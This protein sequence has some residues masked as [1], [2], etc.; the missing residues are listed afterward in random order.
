MTIIA[1]SRLHELSMP[2]LINADPSPAPLTLVDTEVSKYDVESPQDKGERGLAKLYAQVLKQLPESDEKPELLTVQDIPPTSSFGQLRTLLHKI[3]DS[4]QMKSWAAEK[5][6]NLSARNVIDISGTLYVPGSFG[7]GT[8]DLRDFPGWPL[9]KDVATALAGSG[10]SVRFDTATTARVSDIAQFYRHSLPFDPS[11]SPSEQDASITDYIAGWERKGTLIS[12]TASHPSQADLERHA[13]KL[14]DQNNRGAVVA[15]IPKLAADAASSIAQDLAAA[16]R[17]TPTLTEDE[18]LEVSKQATRQRMQE[19]LD[20]PVEIDPTSSYARDHDLKPGVPVTLRE[21]LVGNGLLVPKAPSELAAIAQ[22]LASP[23]PLSPEHGNMGGALSWPTLLSNKDQRTLSRVIDDA[24][25]NEPEDNLLEHLTRDLNLDEKTLKDD[26]GRIIDDILKSSN[27]QAIGRAAEQAIGEIASPEPINDWVLAALYVSLD[28]QSV[29]T[30]PSFST[31]THVAGVELN[32]FAGQ[33]VSYM[34]AALADYL[35]QTGKATP[36]TVDLALFILFSRKAPE[37]LV[38]DIPETLVKGSHAWVTF[39]TAVARIEAHSPGSTRLMT[40][41]QIMERYELAPITLAD[42]MIEALAQ[43]DGLKDWGRGN[44]L[45]RRNAEDKYPDTKMNEIRFAFSKQ[46]SELSK[47]S[48]TFAMEVPDLH[49]WAL[50]EIKQQNPHLS[51]EQIKEKSIDTKEAGFLEFPGPYS[52]LDIFLNTRDH[53]KDID[54]NDYTSR[55]DSIDLTTIAFKPFSRAELKSRFENSLELY[56]NR[57]EAAAQTQTKYLISTLPIEDR[58]II[59]HG[60]ISVGKEVTTDTNNSGVTDKTTASGS[61]IVRSEFTDRNGNES[62]HTYEINMTS[63]TIKKRDDLNDEDITALP[64]E[65]RAGTRSTYLE[66]VVPEGEYPE[67]ILQASSLNT[68][69]DTPNSYFSEKTGYIADAM[70]K[71]LGIRDFAN[72]LRGTT[73]FDTETPF[74]AKAEKFVRGLIPGYNAINNFIDGKWREGLTDLSFDALGFLLSGAGGAAKVA[75]AGVQAGTTTGQVLAQG[76]KKLARGA[77]GALNPIDPVGLG[78][79]GVQTGLEALDRHSRAGDK[80]G[81]RP[82]VKYDVV[83]TFRDV[84]SATIGKANVQGEVED[85]AATQKN[86]KWYALNPVTKQPYGLPLKDFVPS[87]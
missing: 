38:K 32:S 48:D 8:V 51:E 72:E 19:A 43:T 5:G 6:I 28:K 27:A 61:L 39:T 70:T 18:Y 13:S 84:D 58:Q 47:A 37:L 69:N 7:F 65:F 62:T 4:A 85:V 56:F 45:L 24:L 31:R 55:N 23:P 11:L 21:Y 76:A 33:S 16:A 34:R 30:D 75:S 74:W 59:E 46:V 80:N 63:N 71:N 36:K 60:K 57:F 26:P 50:A 77:I 40:Y 9:L 87:T 25:K 53:L 78:L 81:S 41:A 79:A 54:F 83:K 15:V 86:G 17:E 52:L 3:L 73:T 66:S 68:V 64:D 2:A 14:G 42:Q 22:S 1:N 10:T 82:V 12:D 29:F 20:T 35:I 44:G 49:K 67:N